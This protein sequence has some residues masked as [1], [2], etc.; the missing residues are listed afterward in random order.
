MVTHPST[1]RGRCCLTPLYQAA[2]YISMPIT[3]RKMRIYCLETTFFFYSINDHNYFDILTKLDLC[4]SLLAWPGL[5]VYFLKTSQ[6]CM[7]HS[8]SHVDL[9][10]T[11]FLVISLFDPF[12]VVNVWECNSVSMY[13]FVKK[14]F[15]C[16]YTVE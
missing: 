4:I 7:L 10:S 8:L 15:Y 1:N 16:Y 13:C 2:G 3:L 6:I 9:K 5:I 11:K 12:M 14:I